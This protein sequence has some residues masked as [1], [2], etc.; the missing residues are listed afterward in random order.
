MHPDMLLTSRLLTGPGLGSGCRQPQAGGQ[1]LPA[2]FQKDRASYPSHR[3]G[4]EPAASSQAGRES[5]R[6]TW[7]KQ[8]LHPSPPPPRNPAFSPHSPPKQFPAPEGSPRLHHLKAHWFLPTHQELFSFLFFENLFVRLGV[9]QKVTSLF[10]S[11]GKY[12]QSEEQ[13]AVLSLGIYEYSIMP[14]KVR[15]SHS[16]RNEPPKQSKGVESKRF[17][18]FPYEVF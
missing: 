11:E 1:P 5:V 13:S 7:R 10:L 8:G 3:R 2:A 9:T 16:F 14:L 15:V 12:F 6:N 18:I 4:T 17:I